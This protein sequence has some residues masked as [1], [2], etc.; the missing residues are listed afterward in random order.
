MVR[1][2]YLV[3]N[4]TGIGERSWAVLGPQPRTTQYFP[5]TMTVQQVR[6]AVAAQL[7]APVE[8]IYMDNVQ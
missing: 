6:E 7:G 1:V 2:P 8:S 5:I 3:H 4:L